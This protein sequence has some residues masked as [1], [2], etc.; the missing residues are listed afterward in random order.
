MLIPHRPHHCLLL[1]MHVHDRK[2]RERAFPNVTSLQDTSKS[3]YGNTVVCM[4]R[5]SSPT[6]RIIAMETKECEK[7]NLDRIHI[8]RNLLLPIFR[9]VRGLS[10][11]FNWSPSL[12]R[13]CRVIF[14]CDYELQNGVAV[15]Q[16]YTC[17]WTFTTDLALIDKQLYTYITGARA[18]KNRP[19]RQHAIDALLLSN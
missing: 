16:R 13:K 11:S 1:N 4:I 17:R 14:I 7:S 8:R 12:F 10:D 19:L 9:I 6:Q 3:A 15:A 2:A 18:L 5:C